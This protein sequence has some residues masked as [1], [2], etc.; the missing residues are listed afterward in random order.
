MLKRDGLVGLILIYVE[1]KNK[2]E[3]KSFNYIES[4]T[5]FFSIFVFVFAFV[6]IIK[7]NLNLS[8]D[9]SLHFIVI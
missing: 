4:V 7:L 6:G 9:K 5:R 3:P 1:E 8:S 2:E